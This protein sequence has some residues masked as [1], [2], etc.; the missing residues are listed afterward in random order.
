MAPVGG[1]VP[2]MGGSSED[3][4]PASTPQQDAVVVVLWQLLSD[5][6]VDL[7]VIARFQQQILVMVHFEYYCCTYPC[8]G[9]TKNVL[10]GFLRF[11]TRSGGRLADVKARSRSLDIDQ[12]FKLLQ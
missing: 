6:S 11:A 4:T 8:P 7:I 5:P 3:L 9:T 2:L 10:I 12:R 1:F